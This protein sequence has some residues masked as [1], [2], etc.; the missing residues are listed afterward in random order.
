MVIMVN[1]PLRS[2]HWYAA[3]GNT[4]YAHVVFSNWPRSLSL[5]TSLRLDVRLVTKRCSGL[6]R[7][8]AATEAEARASLRDLHA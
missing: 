4:P 1:G 3:T 7:V 2:D 6:I 5:V 8:I